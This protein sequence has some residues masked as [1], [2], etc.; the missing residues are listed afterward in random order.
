MATPRLQRHKVS[1]G[2]AEGGDGDDQRQ[3]PQ[4]EEHPPR[5]S[6]TYEAL[7]LSALVN[8]MS[9]G[10]RM[11]AR[12]RWHYTLTGVKQSQIAKKAGFDETL[13]WVGFSFS[14]TVVIPLPLTQLNRF[15]HNSETRSL[16]IFPYDGWIRTRCREIVSAKCVGPA[17]VPS[18]RCLLISL[19][20]RTQ[21]V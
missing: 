8:K 10:H 2:S 4:R 14:L 13:D 5:P 9:W 18:P 16:H 7:D 20:L 17:P 6:T 19:L 1:F 15:A 11:R 21:V 3:P 12:T